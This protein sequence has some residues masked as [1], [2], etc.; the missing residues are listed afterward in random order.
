MA[1]DA[2]GLTADRR[3]AAAGLDRFRL[4]EER[5]NPRPL[6]AKGLIREQRRGDDAGGRPRE[7]GRPLSGGAGQ[8]AQAGGSIGRG[9]EVVGV[10]AAR[11]ESQDCGLQCRH[12]SHLAERLARLARTG[13]DACLHIRRMRCV[14][15]PAACS[16]ARQ[17]VAA[18]P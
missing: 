15:R 2:G 7:Q 11:A 12:R 16:T 17:D 4:A 1:G 18:V 3:R 6:G 9:D 8:A 5:H 10:R 13:L 14:G